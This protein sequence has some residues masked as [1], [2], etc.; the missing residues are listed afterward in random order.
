MPLRV[1][2]DPELCIG[3]ADCVR[4]LPAAFRLDESLGISVPLPIAANADPVL[5]L[6]ARRN[7]PTHAIGVYDEN[8]DPLA[9]GAG[10]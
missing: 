2:V 10:A 3:S 4:L 5:L 6:R 8:G 7:C 1:S 9:D